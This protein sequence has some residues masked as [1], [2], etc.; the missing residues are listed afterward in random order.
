MRP[1]VAARTGLRRP[2]VFRWGAGAR[3]LF[4]RAKA[5]YRSTGDGLRRIIQLNCGPR[6]GAW[7][8]IQARLNPARRHGLA[9]FGRPSGGS[10]SDVF[11]GSGHHQVHRRPA[12]RAA[13]NQRS[14]RGCLIDKFR[15]L[16]YTILRNNLRAT[17]SSGD[18]DVCRKDHGR[19]RQDARR[20]GR[21]AQ[22]KTRISEGREIFYLNRP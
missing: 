18:R 15:N 20:R 8:A 19:E 17:C 22:P 9:V 13:T 6:V 12:K 2:S 11:T 16:E 3:R 7:W 14:R 10:T 21:F 4:K 5:A 1:I